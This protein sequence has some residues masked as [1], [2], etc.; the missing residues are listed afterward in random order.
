MTLLRNQILSKAF[1][2]WKEFLEPKLHL[3]PQ[4]PKLEET[5]K[6]H[7]W[8]NQFYQVKTEK[9][10]AYWVI[11]MDENAILIKCFSNKDEIAN[12]LHYLYDYLKNKK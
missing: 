8:I 12:Q 3:S 5:N 2:H 9:K 1:L 4:N 10:P 11:T 7:K 6:L